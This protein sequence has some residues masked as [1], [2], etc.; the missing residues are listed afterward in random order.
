MRASSIVELFDIDKGAI[1]RQVHHL[2]ELGLIERDPTPR[3]VG[4]PC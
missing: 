3:T 1:S 2:T 4:R